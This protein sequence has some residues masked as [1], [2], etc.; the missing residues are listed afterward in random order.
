MYELIDS[1]HV[2]CSLNFSHFFYR[3]PPL[4]SQGVKTASIVAPGFIAVVVSLLVWWLANMTK[5]KLQE[6]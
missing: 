6:S 2:N 5:T 1:V 3:S 4:I